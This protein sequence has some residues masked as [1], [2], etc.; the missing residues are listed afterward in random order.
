[1]NVDELTIE[2]K[3]RDVSLGFS[4]SSRNLSIKAGGKRLTEHLNDEECNRVYD[5]MVKG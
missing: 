4:R 5:I 2:L 3:E 1:M